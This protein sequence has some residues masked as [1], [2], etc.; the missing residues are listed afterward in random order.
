MS[1]VVTVKFH[2]NAMSVGSVSLFRLCAHMCQRGLSGVRV[3]GVPHLHGR[4]K[5]L[6]LL[7]LDSD[8]LLRN[9][10]VQI[11]YRIRIR[12]HCQRTAYDKLI[13]SRGSMLL[14]CKRWPHK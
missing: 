7:V 13:V 5:S 3:T 8:G 12:R 4:P 6:Y 11:M 9:A 2:L 14:D 1:L 10:N